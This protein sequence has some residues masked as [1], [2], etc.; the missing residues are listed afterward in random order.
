M[1][2]YLV[3]ILLSFVGFALLAALLLVPVYRFL[4]REEKVSQQWTKEELARRQKQQPPSPNGTTV[5]G[6]GVGE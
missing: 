4:K 2:L 5:P 6:E 3:A 1:D